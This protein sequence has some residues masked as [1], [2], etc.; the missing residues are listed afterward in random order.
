MSKSLVALDPLNDNKSAI[1]LI[2]YMG[3]DLSIVNDARVSYSK[4]SS[5]F[6]EK[7]KKLLN[8]LAKHKHYSPFRGSVLKFRVKCP[9]F[10]ARQWYKHH[11]ASNY[12][13][14][15]DGWNE[16]SFRYTQITAKDFF[17]PDNFREQSNTNKQSGDRPL[18]QQIKA[19]KIFEQACENSY[20]SYQELI[21]LGVCREQARAILVPAIYTEFIWT[22]SLQ[23]LLNFLDLRAKPD[24]QEE[25][26]VYAQGII[27]LIQPIFP[28][29]IA[30]WELAKN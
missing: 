11:I 19:N 22:T 14:E 13:D 20:Q 30:A 23:S 9:L 12:V 7:D 2:D 15:Q 4:Q 1:A 5:N 6:T 21:K 27:E 28:H 8:Y 3:N 10:V 18:L 24:A 17:I 25:I 26:R 29:A 16:K